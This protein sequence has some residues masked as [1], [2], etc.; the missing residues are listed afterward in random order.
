MAAQLRCS[1]CLRRHR[2]PDEWQQIDNEYICP[3]CITLKDAANPPNVVVSDIDG[4]LRVV[5]KSRDD[6]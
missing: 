6:G 4:R 5:S 1:V 2:G 3:E